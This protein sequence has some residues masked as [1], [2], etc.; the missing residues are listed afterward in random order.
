MEFPQIGPLSGEDIVTGLPPV[1]DLAQLG[2]AMGTDATGDGG[3]GLFGEMPVMDEAA[4]TGCRRADGKVIEHSWLPSLGPE[5]PF[6]NVESLADLACWHE[7]PCLKQMEFDA[8]REA[9]GYR[10]ESWCGAFF[11][12]S[13]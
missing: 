9:H 8:S 13:T 12:S 4:L 10:R 11:E 6:W 7:S 5:I 3:K 1:L 2:D